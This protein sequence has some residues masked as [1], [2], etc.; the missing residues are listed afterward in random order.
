M[1]YS[2][3]EIIDREGT[4]CVKWDL[5]KQ[6]FGNADVLPMWVADMDFKTPPFIT[7]A[8]IKRA[9][10][11]V[12]GYTYRTEGYYNSIIN[13][14]ERHHGWKIER[15]SILFSPGV[16]PVL[17]MATLAFTKPGDKI[18]I[19][20]PVYPP[21]FDA[22]INNNRQLVYNP[23]MQVEDRFVIDFEDLDKKLPGTKLMILS[24]PHNPIGRVWTEME[25]KKIGDLCIKHKVILI[26]DEIHCDL[27]LPGYKHICTA[28]LSPEIA[29]N[30]IT[31]IASSKTFNTAGL[32]TSSVIISN[33]EI[34]AKLD[35]VI[36]SVHVDSGNFFGA[37]ASEAAYEHG[38]EWHAKLIEYLAK[39]VAVVRSFLKD[40]LPEI[41]LNAHEA[42][43]LLWL[44][45]RAL[46]LSQPQLVDLI[47]NKAMLGLNDGTAFGVEGTGF[48][49]LNVG[50]PRTMLLDGLSRLEK[51]L[52]E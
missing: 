16:V 19:Q 12:Y 23:L 24:N 39:N 14:M 49:R 46:G 15:K 22:V 26:S 32:S 41:K 34:R 6:I 47:T 18:L 3:D 17:F 52:R 21:F 48:M 1:N 42:T 4:A 40:R 11:A 2:F 51:A 5:R 25:L 13:W 45:F 8:I 10:H 38:D 20:P 36:Q 29:A 33:P 7:E 27:V 50:C 35:A 30:T 43:Y 37:I 28:N 9:S 31:C 44:D